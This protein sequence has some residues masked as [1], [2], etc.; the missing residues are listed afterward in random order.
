MDNVTIELRAE[1]KKTYLRWLD[2]LTYLEE[3]NARGGLTEAGMSSLYNTKE[4]VKD[5]IAL[6]VIS[7]DFAAPK[8]S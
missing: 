1:L 4:I 6:M 8:P 7:T 2:K 5:L 3:E